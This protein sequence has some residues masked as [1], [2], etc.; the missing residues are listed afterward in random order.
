MTIDEY[1]TGRPKYYAAIARRLR[2][3]ERDIDD[4]VQE[5]MIGVAQA[6]EDHP[7]MPDK[8]YNKVA[9][10]R[11]LNLLRNNTRFTGT[12]ARVAH[13]LDPLRR[14]DWRSMD[15]Y[16][17]VYTGDEHYVDANL[18]YHEQGFEWV[19]SQDSDLAQA[20]SALNERQRAIALGVARG[21]TLA[22]IAEDLGED[23]ISTQW[24]YGTRPKLRLAVE[25]PTF[26]D[27]SDV[28]GVY[29]CQTRKAWK[30]SIRDGSKRY[31]KTR[32]SKE[33]AEAVAA[34]I[35]EQIRQEREA[36]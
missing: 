28:P 3:P 2:V 4:F 9:Q 31:Q 17:M 11:M 26:P 1:L 29:W 33:G 10:Y 7:G 27:E 18:H 23:D 21:D 5:A 20:V 25:G 36:A 15:S 30:V 22:E 35:R 16:G 13:T 8:Y 6:Y 14:Q 34:E 24:R 32:V 12:A 19:E